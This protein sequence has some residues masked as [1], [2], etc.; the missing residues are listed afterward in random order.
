LKNCAGENPAKTEGL[1]FASCA[2]CDIKLMDAI[3][4]TIPTIIKNMILVLEL[5][6]QQKFGISVCKVL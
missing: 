3:R 2:F 6:V 5:Q 4:M 1:N